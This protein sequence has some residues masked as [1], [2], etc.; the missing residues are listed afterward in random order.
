[1][2]DWWSLG[3]NLLWIIG[4]AIILTAYS[5]HY[6][7]ATVSKRRLAQLVE[8]RS[9]QL[10]SWSGFLLVCLGVLFTSKAV[11][12]RVVWVAMTLVIIVNLVM[13]WRNG[14]VKGS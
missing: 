10:A 2:I 8:T 13:T 5:Y 14:R 4:A 9:F 1:M 11:W 3:V 7:I 6:W 12:E